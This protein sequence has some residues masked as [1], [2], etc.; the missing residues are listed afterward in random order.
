[1]QDAL[2]R[3]EA[4]SWLRSWDRQQECYLP[5][6]EE[7][8]R[9]LVGLVYS[10]E[11]RPIRV[12]D[13][14]CGPGSLTSR[15][16]AARPRTQIVAVDFD[17]V[18]L[19]IYRALFPA[20]TAVEADLREDGWSR[21]I[22]GHFDAVVTATALHWL[23]GVAVQQLYRELGTLVRPGGVFLNADHDPLDECPALSRRCAAVLDRERDKLK[24]QRHDWETWWRNVAEHPVF[25][26]M[27]AERNRRFSDRGE[28]FV[29][30]ARWHLAALANAGF[31]EQA[32][33]WRRGRDAIVA[34]TK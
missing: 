4:E 6:R 17:P 28:E 2:D 7:R 29:P 25:G 24:G 30:P 27:L 23:D 9:F 18:L 5:D 34:A 8:F 22:E 21:K 19:S 33:V 3:S 20:A 12:L 31:S 13:L 10:V 16:L 32:V 11:D 15:L 14:A 26:S 1:M